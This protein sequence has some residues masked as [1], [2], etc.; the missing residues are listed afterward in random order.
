MGKLFDESGEPLYS[1]WAKKGQRRYRYLVSKRLVRG[2]A[3]P[4]D[5]GW[6][7]PAE[8]I[9]QAVIVGIRQ[10]LSGRGALASTLK[11]G[12]FAAAELKPAIEAVD[13]KVKSHQ[14]RTRRIRARLSSESS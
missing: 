14:L 6:R 1:C 3:K 9:E 4:D 2:T 5:R 12:G 13:A 7:L 11:A 8:P 10:M